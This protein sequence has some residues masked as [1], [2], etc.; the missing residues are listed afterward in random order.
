MQCT[1]TYT[2]QQ[3]FLKL[4]HSIDNAFI[5]KI[6]TIAYLFSLL[7]KSKSYIIAHCNSLSFHYPS[8][9]L[10]KIKHVKIVIRS[11]INLIIEQNSALCVLSL[12]TTTVNWRDE[13][14]LP[15]RDVVHCVHQQSLELCQWKLRFLIGFPQ[16]DWSKDI[17]HTNCGQMTVG[18]YDSI[19]V[20]LF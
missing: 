4:L 7:I 1:Y 17:G 10:W 20:A 19:H 6:F 3:H 14:S 18:R 8:K 5:Y 2:A 12:C 13:G 11:S 16:L 15:C 9:C